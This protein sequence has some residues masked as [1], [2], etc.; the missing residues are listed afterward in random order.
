LDDQ[1][2]KTGRRGNQSLVS[3]NSP[4]KRGR[5]LMARDSEETARIKKKDEKRGE[6]LLH[7]ER[8]DLR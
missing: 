6:I 8:R 3:L 1:A 2:E 4:K 7:Q 5:F